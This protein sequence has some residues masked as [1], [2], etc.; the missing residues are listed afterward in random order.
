MRFRS[1]AAASLA[2]AVALSTLAACGSSGESKNEITI[3]YQRNTNN[4]VRYM[5]N[6]LGTVKKQFEKSH[7]GKTVKLV[8]IQATENDYYTKLDLMMKS[9]RTAPDLAYE[10]TF[11]I[12]S[13]IKAGFLQPIDSRVKT[14]SQWSKFFPTAKKSVT[15]LDGKV[16]GVPDGTDTRGIWYD[17]RIFRKAGLPTTWQ[18]KSWDDLLAA[19]RQIKKKVP[20][21]TPMNVYTGKANG[22]YAAMQGFE[23]LLYGTDDQ[24]YN[25]QQKKWVVGSKG[26]RDSLQFYKTVYS[27]GL[28]PKPSAALDANIA[29]NIN[30]EWL[31]ASKIGFTIDG[32][33]TANNWLPTGG[34]PWKQWSKDLGWAAMPT[35]HGQAPG[36]TSM[37]GGWSWA[38]TRQAKNPDLAWEFIK[39]MQTEKNAMAYDNASQNIAVRSDVAADPEYLKAAP[40]V[41]FFT[42]LVKYTHYRPAYAEYP[43]LSTAITEQ[44]EA[45]TTGSSSPAQ[46]AADYDK[47]VRDI[48]GAGHT[49]KVSGTKQ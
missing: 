16:Y 43:K 15:A 34:K 3:A 18:P 6:F 42:D 27:T 5:D 24:L 28:A 38:I 14:W 11:L 22:E 37:S 7:P 13:D 39:S 21:V 2:G 19:A 29:N 47:A 26:F 33:F 1:I 46:A 49:T 17:K 30:L 40:T 45:V 44:Q 25:P 4:N 48:V 12:N 20:G 9:P 36:K 35:Q 8:P 32:S 41:K 31:P 10:D 23:M